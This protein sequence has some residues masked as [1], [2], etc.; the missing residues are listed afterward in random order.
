M[1]EVA[2]VFGS[3]QKEGRFHRRF[4]HVRFKQMQRYAL[5][6]CFGAILFTSRAFIRQDFEVRWNL[7]KKQIRKLVPSRHQLDEN[8][9]APSKSLR[10]LS[11]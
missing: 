7:K 1:L 5:L 3:F 8:Q 6:Q 10:S 2:V 4:P 11:V 9:S